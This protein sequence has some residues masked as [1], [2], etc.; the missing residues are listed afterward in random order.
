MKVSVTPTFSDRL[1]EYFAPQL[2]VE[3]RR[4]RAILAMTG[5]YK[6]GRRDRRALRNWRFKEASA[7]ADTLDD[8]P[9]LRARSREL[10]RNIP[11]ATGAIST[12]VT[13]V[14]GDGL[15]GELVLRLAFS[16]TAEMRHDDNGR[17]RGQRSLDCRQRC[18]DAGIGSHDPIG[19]G[20]IQILT[21]QH[22]FAR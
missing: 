12:V 3:R 11:I 2:G 13:N 5:G 21:D 22:P 18:P 4:A 15:Q 6:G 14:I 1:V 16:R 10:V 9:D 17:I 20:Y 7:D 19:H 8:L